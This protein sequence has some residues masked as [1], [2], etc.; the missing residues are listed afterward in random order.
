[1]KRASITLLS[2]LLGAGTAAAQNPPATADFVKHAEVGGQTE[3]QA[4]QIAEKKGHTPAVKNFGRDMVRDHTKLSNE[5]KA[6]LAKDPDTSLPKD[7]PLD[8][9]AKA[10]LDKFNSA[11]PADF[12]KT[13]IDAMVEDHKKDLAEFESYAKSGQDK[14]IREAAK[15][16]VPVIKRHLAMAEKIQRTQNRSSG[17][18]QTK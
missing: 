2:I 6:T 12:D 7:T 3:V 4:G 9:E 5:L 13:Y 10:T 8:D 18:Y 16:A 15:K 1:M 17:T 11:S 14:A